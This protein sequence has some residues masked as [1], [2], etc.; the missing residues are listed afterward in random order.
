LSPCDD[1]LTPIHRE[2]QIRVLKIVLAVNVVMF[3]AEGAGGLIFR[4]MALLGDA[5]DML[6][7]ALVYGLSLY[8]IDRG[9]RWK[10]RAALIKGVV[11]LALG[12]GVLVQ[13]VRHSLSGVVPAAGGM[14]LV[15]L[16]ALAANAFCLFLLYKHREDDLN[17]R[18]TW[19]C[20]RNDVIANAGVIA[21]A[22][23]V[24]WLGSPWPDISMG[25]VIAVMI[26]TSSVTLLKEA[27]RELKETP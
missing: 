27:R 12:A 19:L 6:E 23:L 8:V 9:P 22:V 25:A 3:L 21:A 7:D 5:L 15:A 11:M 26:L 14:S 17:M 10:A 2:D 24:R 13:T 16:A 18:S 1:C 20:S 4:S